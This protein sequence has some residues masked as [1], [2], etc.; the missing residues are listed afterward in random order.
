MHAVMS[1]LSYVLI[2]F[3][4][5]HYSCVLSLLTRADAVENKN[6]LYLEAYP[7]LVLEM[8]E[9]GDLFNQI[10]RRSRVTEHFLAVSFLSAMRALHSIH[11]RGFIHRDLKLDNIMC[12]QQKEPSEVKIIDFG[13]MI[14]RC[15]CACAWFYSIWNDMMYNCIE[16]NYCTTQ[17]TLL[18]IVVRHSLSGSVPASRQGDGDRGLFR[19]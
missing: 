1:T 2:S 18:S 14:G 6:P 7:V 16:L 13:M 9:G 11:E 15:A 8:L 4:L 17:L 10:A 19:P 12:L 3:L 5:L